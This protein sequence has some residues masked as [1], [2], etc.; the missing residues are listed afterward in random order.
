M[1]KDEQSEIQELQRKINIYCI[2]E[3]REHMVNLSG[4][5]TMLQQNNT[6]REQ[7]WAQQ[8]NDINQ[9]LTSLRQAIPPNSSQARA[10]VVL[11]PTTAVLGALQ[12][13]HGLEESKAARLPHGLR[14]QAGTT[15]KRRNAYAPP[16]PAG[17]LE[18]QGSLGPNMGSAHP[19]HCSKWQEWGGT[20][21]LKAK[22]YPPTH[23]KD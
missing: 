4:G 9:W 12:H 13:N 14:Q 5:F 23:P 6:Q 10:R 21:S 17:G 15:P 16:T 22:R 18:P 1:R 20:Y 3:L 11:A 7:Q 19:S 8:Q 2:N